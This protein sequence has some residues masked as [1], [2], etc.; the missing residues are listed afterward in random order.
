MSTK[1]WPLYRFLPVYRGN[2][3]LLASLL[4]TFLV[5]ID[6]SEASLL[7]NNYIF[8][9]LLFLTERCNLLQSIAGP[10]NEF[11]SATSF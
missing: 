4:E 3:V 1:N 8:T 7:K 11:F 10:T 6:F 9:V 5:P 2:I